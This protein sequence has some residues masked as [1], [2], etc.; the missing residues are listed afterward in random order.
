MSGLIAS[1]GFVL[2]LGT[3]APLLL[4]L[5]VRHPLLGTGLALA[6]AVAEAW[7]PF[8]PA[9]DLGV[10]VFPPDFVYLLLGGAAVLRLAPRG[11][12]PLPLLLWLGFGAVLLGSFALGVVGFG[13]EAGVEFRGSFYF[14]VAGLYLA[15]FELDPRFGRGLVHLWMWAALLVLGSAVFRWTAV[16]LG[17]EFARAWSEWSGAGEGMRLRVVNAQAT[18]VLAV[19]LLLLIHHRVRG[20][21]LRSWEWLG[22]PLAL[23]VLV[24]QHR[25]VWAATLAGVAAIFYI[26]RERRGRLLGAALLVGMLGAV[27]V[28]PV[29]DSG[30]GQSV[31]TEVSSSATAA[32]STEGGTFVGRVLSWRELLGQY[33]GLGPRGWLVGEPFGAGY[34]RVVE[35]MHIEYSPHNQYVQFLLRVG[36]L[37]TALWLAAYTLVLRRLRATP[38]PPAALLA[39]VLWVLVATQL[40]FFIPYQAYHVQGLLLGVALTAC[41]GSAR[42]PA[43]PAGAQ[44]AA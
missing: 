8:M 12:W 11:Q 15:S 41:A 34:S 24:L 37:G 44:V 13:T 29:L 43:Q 19:A 17:L 9:I 4:A 10:K 21:P 32:V 36:A 30:L 18:L 7:L 1:F 31:V 20:E 39:G 23:A 16:A 3:A 26:E 38:A 35:G 5:L 42:A 22:V 33:A 25:S 27:A 28:V 2:M 40:V 14:W 6:T